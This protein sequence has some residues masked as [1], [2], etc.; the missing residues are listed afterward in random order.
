M[1]GRLL[2]GF[3]QTVYDDG[4]HCILNCSTG[5]S[6]LARLSRSHSLVKSVK[7]C[8]HITIKTGMLAYVWMYE[9]LF[10]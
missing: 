1:Y 6:D 9:L 3:C 10:I 5:F 4:L 8:T 2:S 7:L